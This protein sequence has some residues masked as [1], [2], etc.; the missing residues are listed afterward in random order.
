V[1]KHDASRIVQ[2]VVKY[3]GQKERDEIAG[4][5]KGSYRELSQN[6]Y[7]KVR[8]FL[9]VCHFML[10]VL[11]FLVTKLI[12]F[13]SSH[14]PSILLEFQSYVPRMLLHRE[15]SA[16]LADAFELYANAYE[17]AILLRDFYGKEVALFSQATGSDQEKE[18]VKRGLRGVLEDLSAERRKRVLGAV[19]ENLL[20]M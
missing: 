18:K 17:R 7:S 5:L 10:T 16:V 14:R 9:Y 2:S 20:S 15:A 11:Q 4:E 8:P 19:K 6:K 3:G 12:R 1:F 13:S